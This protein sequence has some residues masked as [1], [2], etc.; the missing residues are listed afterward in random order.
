MEECF[1]NPSTKNGKYF[2]KEIFAFSLP[3]SKRLH[4]G[5]MICNTVVSLLFD[6][7]LTLSIIFLFS[8]SKK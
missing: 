1:V 7:F 2:R 5:M 4:N 6:Y 8:Y 3:R